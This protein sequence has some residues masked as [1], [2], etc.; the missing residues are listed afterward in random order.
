MDLIYY[1]TFNNE[2]VSK[3]PEEDAG[4]APPER[5]IKITRSPFIFNVVIEHWVVLRYGMEYRLDIAFT[6]E[7]YT[8]QRLVDAFRHAKFEENDCTP[9]YI[10]YFSL[11][12][13][14]FDKYV[15]QLALNS[16]RHF[17]PYSFL[18]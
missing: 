18:L 9:Q 8:N 6:R 15:D 10:R 7:E 14:L 1:D 16:V 13:D 12:S 2:Y 5:Y 4:I 17:L 3:I 11:P